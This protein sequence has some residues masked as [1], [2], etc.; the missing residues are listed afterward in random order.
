MQCPLC[1]HENLS[2]VKFCGE[3]GARLESACPACGTSNPPTNKFCGQCGVS[4]A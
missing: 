3:C 2:G 1:Q 4:L